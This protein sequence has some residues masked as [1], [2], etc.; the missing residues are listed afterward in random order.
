MVAPPRERARGIQ[1]Q[2]AGRAGGL[3]PIPHT[4]RV[5]THSFSASLRI[6]HARSFEPT[7]P[8]IACACVCWCA[9]VRRCAGMIDLLRSWDRDG[10][11]KISRSEF[12]TALKRYGCPAKKREV[13]ELFQQCAP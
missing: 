2:L 6:I 4:L 7:R 3:L 9:S 1:R 12:R 13:H 8:E 5:D 11:G 10:D